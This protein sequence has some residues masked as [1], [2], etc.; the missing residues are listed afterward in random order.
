[1]SADDP[2]PT[3]YIEGSEYGDATI[4]VVGLEDERCQLQ[5]APPVTTGPPPPSLNRQAEM[6]S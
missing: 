4:W 1:M 2:W 3:Y 6:L 5:L